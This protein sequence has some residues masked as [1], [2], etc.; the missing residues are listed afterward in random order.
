MIICTWTM[1]LTYELPHQNFLSNLN[2]IRS[3]VHNVIRT[4]SKIQSVGILFE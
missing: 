2:S 3:C 1:Y 4:V